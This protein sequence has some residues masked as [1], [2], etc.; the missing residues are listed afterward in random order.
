ME[1]GVI[2]SDY[3]RP[4]GIPILRGRNF[5]EGDQPATATKIIIDERMADAMWPGEDPI[6][7]IV[8]RG[9]GANRIPGEGDNE[10][11]GAGA[12]LALCGIDG[13]PSDYYQGY[14][15]QSQAGFN[16]LT[17]VLRT[18]VS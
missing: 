4:L 17:F 14:L 12:A 18:A 11:I 16:E 2:D 6:G 7:K 5:N 15:A 8:Y 9:R 1:M 13:G 10:G 3:F